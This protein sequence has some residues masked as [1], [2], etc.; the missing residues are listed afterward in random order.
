MKNK[1][2]YKSPLQYLKTFAWMITVLLGYALI[3]SY[4]QDVSFSQVIINLWFLP[5]LMMGILI[6]YEQILGRFFFKNSKPNPAKNFISHVSLKAKEELYLTKDEFQDLNKHDAFQK[7]M[8]QIYQLF[9]AKE[10]EKKKYK[11]HLKSFLE[12]STEYAVIDLV[13]REALK[14]LNQK[15]SE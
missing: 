15:E 13:I 5:I 7:S 8:S 3:F 14:I 2:G 6:V 4:F 1:P 12:D 9:L 11:K 10:I